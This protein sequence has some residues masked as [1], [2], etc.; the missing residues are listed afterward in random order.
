MRNKSDVLGK[1]GIMLGYSKERLIAYRIYDLKY[2]KV[3][4]EQSVKF[5]VVKR[6]FL[7]KKKKIK[8]SNLGC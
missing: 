8:F 4:E 1:C 5:N 7:F 6:Q 3:I 2:E